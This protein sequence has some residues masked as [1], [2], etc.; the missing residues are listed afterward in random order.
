MP[1]TQFMFG[2]VGHSPP[3]ALQ[4]PFRAARTLT[5]SPAS[6]SRC[7][8]RARRSGSALVKITVSLFDHSIEL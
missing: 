7:Q 2:L 3:K 8:V 1:R 6:G 4:P 5:K